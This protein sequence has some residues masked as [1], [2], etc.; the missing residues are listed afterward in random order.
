[1]KF[2]TVTSEISNSRFKKQ[3]WISLV[4][5]ISAY[6]LEVVVYKNWEHGNVVF[7]F[8]DV[9]EISFFF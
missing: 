4:L 2:N 8:K 5:R 1:M 3:N 7:I 6:S 9:K